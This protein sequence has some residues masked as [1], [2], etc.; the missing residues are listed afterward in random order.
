MHI[1]HITGHHF[2]KSPVLMCLCE[3]D[4]SVLLL[5]EY[6]QLFKNLLYCLKFPHLRIYLF[7][8]IKKKEN[9][10]MLLLC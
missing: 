3:G 4:T 6:Y 1:K 7:T 8:E 5:S 9:T 10:S 2:I